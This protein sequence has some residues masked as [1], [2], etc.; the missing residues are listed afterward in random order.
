VYTV[1]WHPDRWKEE[2]GRALAELQRVLRPGGALIL[3]ETLGTGF[4]SPHPPG[5]LLAYFQY[6][7]EAGF[8][9]TW[10]RTDYRFACMEEG[11]D[12]TTYF[13]GADILDKFSSID[14]AI[15]PECT[16]IWWITKN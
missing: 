5:D 6:L 8:A 1:V 12:L 14:P 13:F 4:E 9:S 11:K 3:L 7:E 15:L 2:L 16:G 10:I